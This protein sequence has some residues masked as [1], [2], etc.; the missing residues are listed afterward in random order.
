MRNARNLR[1]I[2]SCQRG[3]PWLANPKEN[4]IRG[5]VISVEKVI[6]LF[7]WSRTTVYTPGIIEDSLRDACAN[8]Q[9]I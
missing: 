4:L 5:E 7:S 3:I 9:I 6:A 8:M 2:D 1:G